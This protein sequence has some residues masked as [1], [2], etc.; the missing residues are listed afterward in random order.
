MSYC[1]K[2]GCLSPGATVRANTQGSHVASVKDEAGPHPPK[3]IGAEK[4]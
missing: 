1:A 3:G 4:C 2:Q